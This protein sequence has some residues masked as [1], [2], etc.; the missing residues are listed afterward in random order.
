M[1]IMKSYTDLSSTQ[2]S[3]QFGLTNHATA[4]HHIRAAT[5]YLSGEFYGDYGFKDEYYKVLKHLK[6]Q[7][8][9]KKNS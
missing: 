1:H 2:I 5:D 7:N 4:L 9:D 3:K 8:N 6:L